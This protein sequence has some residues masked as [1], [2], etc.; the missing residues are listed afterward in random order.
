MIDGVILGF[1]WLVGEMLDSLLVVLDAGE[2]P[3]VASSKTR[4][5]KIGKIV[6][7]FIRI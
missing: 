1:E 4:R 6:K 7:R 2:L 3:Q 5:S